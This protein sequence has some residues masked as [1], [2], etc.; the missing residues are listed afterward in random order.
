[1]FRY[2]QCVFPLHLTI[3]NRKVRC[4]FPCDPLTHR[5]LFI[6]I[7]PFTLHMRLMFFTEGTKKCSLFGGCGFT[8]REVLLYTPFF[9]WNGSSHY[10]SHHSFLKFIPLLS[11]NRHIQTKNYFNYK[12]TARNLIFKHIIEMKK[13]FSISFSI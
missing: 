11:F 5:V 13:L 4:S 7:V 1:L 8:L 10:Y 3:V 12:H 9:I 6:F 2:D